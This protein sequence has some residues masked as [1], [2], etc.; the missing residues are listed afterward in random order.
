[1]TDNLHASGA[2]PVWQWFYPFYEDSYVSTLAAP[3]DM[4]SRGVYP[5]SLV[6]N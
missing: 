2:L 3:K 6:S 1:L 4:P 5:N